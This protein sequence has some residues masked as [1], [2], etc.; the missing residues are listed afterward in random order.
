MAHDEALAELARRYFT[1]RGPATLQDFVWWSGLTTADARAGLKAI[2]ADLVRE[3]IDGRTYWMSR[4]TTPAQNSSPAVHLLP[5]F[6]EYLLGYRDRGASLDAAYAKKLNA[7][8]A[9]SLPQ[10]SQTAGSWAPG[11]ARSGRTPSL[12]R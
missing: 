6:D 11:D 2:T 12:S 5:G 8:A 7:G 4:S 10:S 1:S 3:T 9:C